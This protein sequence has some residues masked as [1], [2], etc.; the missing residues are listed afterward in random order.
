[1]LDVLI[2]ESKATSKWVEVGRLAVRALVGMLAGYLVYLPV[3][4][5]VLHTT[6][7]NIDGERFFYGLFLPFQ[8]PL[9]VSAAYRRG[10]TS[11][12]LLL[13]IAGALFLALGALV[14]LLA[15]H[16]FADHR[17][18]ARIAAH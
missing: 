10:C 15:R 13:D 12:E 2:E 16:R 11:D 18:H 8:S 4:A 9:L 5:T 1:M 6:D 3:L 14:S 7:G 17:N